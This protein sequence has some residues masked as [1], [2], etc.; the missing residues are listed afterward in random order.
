MVGSSPLT[1]EDLQTELKYFAQQVLQQQ[2]L[3]LGDRI[4]QFVASKLEQEQLPTPSSKKVAELRISQNVMVKGKPAQDQQQFSTRQMQGSIQ[5][6]GRAAAEA[7]ALTFSRSEEHLWLLGPPVMN[8]SPSVGPL[9]L[10]GPTEW[11]EDHVIC[12]DA[13]PPSVDKSRQD[14]SLQK[15]VKRTEFDNF[16]VVFILLNTLLIGAQT[17]YHARHLATGDPW[18]FIAADRLF[19]AVFVSE[20]VLRI[21]ADGC[22]E[23]LF[24]ENR[25]WHMFDCIVVMMQVMEQVVPLAIKVFGAV[26]FMPFLRIMRVMRMMRLLRIMR[27]GRLLHLVAPLRMLIVSVVG[28]FRFLMWTLCLLALQTYMCGIILTDMVTEKREAQSSGEHESHEE[29]SRMWGSLDRSMLTLYQIVTE[30]IHWGEAM[31]P[32]RDIPMIT[33]VFVLYVAFSCFAL[34][35]VITGIFVDSALNIAEEE[36]KDVLM[37]Q[38]H[39]HF[40]EFDND[41]SGEV[42]FEEFNCCL[43]DPRMRPFLKQLDI[44]SHHGQLLFALMDA[45]ESGKIDEEE[46]IAGF[47]SLHGTAR[48]L[49]LAALMR[50]QH[51]RSKKWQEHA[52]SVEK[53]LGLPQNEQ[54]SSSPNPYQFMHVHKSKRR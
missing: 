24:G 34:M 44:D 23:F 6:Y 2:L 20:L 3:L 13:A 19:C 32:L 29:I 14:S 5:V 7:R 17:D 31:G 50:D 52:D 16:T 27:A 1:L 48:R 53:H 25:G 15:F 38:M 42:S 46:L 10:S 41:G 36:K 45:D 35:N 22:K 39:K 30:G 33:T 21:A 51:L 12:E 54:R 4:E 28:S 9:L 43:T 40:A 26:G 11:P 37:K 18:F 8:E 49:E 47:M